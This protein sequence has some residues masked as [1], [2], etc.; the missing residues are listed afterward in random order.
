MTDT[1]TIHA[2]KTNLSSLVASN[3]KWLMRGVGFALA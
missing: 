2:A 1:I 3:S